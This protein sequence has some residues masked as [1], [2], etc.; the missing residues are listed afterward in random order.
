MRK[1][2][3]DG[4]IYI[5]S[6]NTSDNTIKTSVVNSKFSS[7]EVMASGGAISLQLSSSVHC[8]LLTTISKSNFEHNKAQGGGGVVHISLY[9]KLYRKR[10]VFNRILTNIE[11]SMFISNKALQDG[12]GSIYIEGMSRRKNTFDTFIHNSTF[13]LTILHQGEVL[14]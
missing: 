14:S 11:H 10:Y 8:L 4:A 13:I 3:Y 5:T 9:Q 7:N 6:S 1:K 2:T 12:G